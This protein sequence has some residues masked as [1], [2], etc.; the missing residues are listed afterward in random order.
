MA[1]VANSF[2]KSTLQQVGA[3]ARKLIA[4]IPFFDK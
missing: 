1:T 2:A 4:S 3:A